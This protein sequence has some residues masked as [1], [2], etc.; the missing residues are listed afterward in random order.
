MA[1][2]SRIVRLDGTMVPSP[3]YYAN[4]GVIVYHGMVD[5]VAVADGDVA[6]LSG[7]AGGVGSLAGQ[8]AKLR[9]AR[10]VIGSSGSDERTTYLTDELGFDAAIN[11]KSEDVSAELK[12]LAP[13]G[14]SVIFDV[15]GGRQS[16]SAI[17]NA[18]TGARFTLCGALSSQVTKD[19]DMWP[20]FNLMTANTKNLTIRPF[21]TYH[22]PE[23]V[24]AWNTH[25]G[26]WLGQSR[27]VF[28]H[29]ELH[30]PLTDAPHALR[31]LLAG[32]YTGNVALH[33][34]AS[35]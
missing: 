25:F 16:E 19:R 1:N 28:P 3:A 7:A 10:L 24:D 13:D 26:R 4:Q 15:V 29:T 20:R 35:S 14:V 6:F 18:S 33:L 11:Y 5:V 12:R 32:E 8:I 27:L 9:G 17:E 30:G 2:A 21:A 23:Q 34:T 22:T 31:A